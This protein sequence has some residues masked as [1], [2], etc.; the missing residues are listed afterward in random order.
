M[1][2]CVQAEDNL[3]QAFCLVGE[4]QLSADH[5]KA[6]IQVI[7]VFDKPYRLADFWHSAKKQKKNGGGVEVWL[8]TC[9]I[10]LFE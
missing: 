7:F 10:V 4:L 8:L 9:Y 6:S 2:C 3:A 5:C 1:I